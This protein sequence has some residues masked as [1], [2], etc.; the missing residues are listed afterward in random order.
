M[1]KLNHRFSIT[2][3]LVSLLALSIFGQSNPKKILPK[4][5]LIAHRGASGYAP[6]HTAA[7]YK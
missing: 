1:V 4:K 5:T 7:A 6:E 2:A 3:L